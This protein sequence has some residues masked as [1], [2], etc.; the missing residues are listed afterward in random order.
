MITATR[1]IARLL[2]A[3]FALS[4]LSTFAA[5]QWC[6][7]ASYNPNHP[8]AWERFIDEVDSNIDSD[9]VIEA[10]TQIMTRFDAEMLTTTPT[11]QAATL[12]NAVAQYLTYIKQK[13]RES[14][15]L[16]EP[17][18]P[19]P[20]P[21]Q[22]LILQYQLG[23]LADD[24]SSGAYKI[25]IGCDALPVG[26]NDGLRNI[27]YA[28]YS[29]RQVALH[30]DFAIAAQMAQ[31]QASTVYQS[32]HDYVM[33]GL[34]MWPWELWLNGY[35]VPDDFNKPAP[36][37]QW[38]FLRPNAS[39]AVVT[40][41][42]DADVDFGLTLEAGHI[43]YRKADYSEWWGL[44]AMVAVTDSEGTGYGGLFRWNNYTLGVARHS[45]GDDETLIY[46]SVDLYKYILG[47]N[48]RAS[49][50]Q[51]FLDTIK[52]KAKS[53]FSDALGPQ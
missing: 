17:A 4:P 42:Q 48:G 13:G 51:G 1:S 49:S 8:L 5:P 34:P 28:L 26:G 31:F 16:F 20:T 38:V 30:K 35:L 52:A 24:Q 44:S 10:Y 46:L 12:N 3:V 45:K 37:R 43:W 18:G 33:K 25:T 19:I 36:R 32:Y 39:P 53:R 50:T 29:L 41:A 21:N 15:A 2:V 40:G 27:A 47:E 11:P 23:P 22:G 6:G 7:N 9:R 14:P